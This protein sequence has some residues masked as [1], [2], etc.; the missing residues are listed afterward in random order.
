MVAITM[1][2]TT[3]KGA[4]KPGLPPKRV[5]SKSPK[6][7]TKPERLS[8]LTP[9]PKGDGRGVPE[10]SIDEVLA[11]PMPESNAPEHALVAFVKRQHGVAFGI[12]KKVTHAKWRAGWGLVAIKAGPHGK[13]GKWTAFCENTVGLDR[14]TVNNY[15]AVA[16]SCTQEEAQSKTITQLYEDKGIVKF[17]TRGYG[18]MIDDL[19]RCD[20]MAATIS[21]QVEK[22]AK[23]FED[24]LDGV[25][26]RQANQSKII[27]VEA[28]C[29][30]CAI[31]GSLN[32]VERKLKKT[33]DRLSTF[34]ERRWPEVKDWYGAWYTDNKGP[35]GGAPK[36]LSAG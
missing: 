28:Y 31:G 17:T 16:L 23:C 19:K 5:K 24:A 9:A 3:V 33:V 15:I 21:K 18:K 10:R 11:E 34:C 20:E 1:P 8:V 2:K 25:D 7:R 12:G 29:Y 27:A 14:K 13:Y 6:G 36:P 35:L 4:A 30:A 22:V 26:A 32:S